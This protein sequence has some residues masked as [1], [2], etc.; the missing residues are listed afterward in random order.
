MRKDCSALLTFEKV[1]IL[2]ASVFIFFEDDSN[3]LLV[4]P[5]DQAG[6]VPGE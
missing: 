4:S 6:S 1:N 3:S 5:S 2:A